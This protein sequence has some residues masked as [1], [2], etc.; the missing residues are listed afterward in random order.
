MVTA[1]ARNKFSL[2]TPI[3]PHTDRESKISP[4]K[5]DELKTMSLI[6]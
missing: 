5:K 3:S 1:L 6:V 4:M 2:R